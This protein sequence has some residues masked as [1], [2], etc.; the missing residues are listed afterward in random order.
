MSSSHFWKSS[1]LSALFAA[2]LPGVA[3]VNAQETPAAEAESQEIAEITVTARRREESLQDVPIAVSAF[4]AESL[5]QIGAVDITTL[6][7]TTPNL[8]L[9]VARGSN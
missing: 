7:Q 8:T 5:E 2:V 9:Q 3:P 6:Q 1:S 4:S